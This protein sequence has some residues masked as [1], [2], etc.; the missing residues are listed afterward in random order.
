M[1]THSGHTRLAG[2]I[3]WP[4]SHSLSPR[5]HGFWLG[6]YAIDGAYVALPV[7]SAHLEQAVRGLPALG[8]AGAN[9]TVPHK[10]PVLTLMDEVSE[11]A[12]RIGAVN[13][14]VCRDDGTLFGD[15]TDAYGFLNN[16]TSSVPAWC[17]DA[18]PALVLGAGGASRAVIDALLSGGCPEV[19]LCNR[20]P[21]RAETVAAEFGDRVRPVAWE[22]RGDAGADIGV[23]VNTTSLGMVGQPPLEMPLDLVPATA[24]VTDIVYNPL[25]TPLLA[26]AAARG[27]STV[28][29]LGMLLHQ[30][31]PGFAAWFGTTPEVSAELRAFVLAAMQA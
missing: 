23:L 21:T 14:I 15:N 24:V 26:A 28:D 4:V 17:A 3:G 29:G 13:T 25:E 11:T 12:A 2:V 31:V 18:A 22:D 10:E 7:A 6:T 9:V 1:Q 19:R 30:A 20:T 16:L 8:F 27:L 5:L